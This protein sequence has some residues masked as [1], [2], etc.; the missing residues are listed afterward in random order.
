M[1]LRRSKL[2]QN[3]EIVDMVNRVGKKI[4]EVT[5]REYGT[6]NYNW[7]FYL[8]EDDNKINAFCLSDGKVFVYSGL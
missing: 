2:S 3:R 1:I 5:N 7:K 4:S 8:I 6:T